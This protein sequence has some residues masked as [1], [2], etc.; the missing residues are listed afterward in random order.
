MSKN[1][2]I[3]SVAER[4]GISASEVSRAFKVGYPM[5]PEKRELIKKTAAEMGYVRNEAAS[6]LTMKPIRF[7]VICSNDFPEFDEQLMKGFKDA[8]RTYF[9]YKLMLSYHFVEDSE[10]TDRLDGMI[11]QFIDEGY[12]AVLIAMCCEGVEPVVKKYSEKIRIALVNSDMPQSGRL[13]AAVNNTVSVA[14]IAAQLLYSGEKESC[15]VFTGVRG[16]WNHVNILESFRQVWTERGCEIACVY[17]S[18]SEE[19]MRR[20]LEEAFSNH[21]EITCVYATSALSV[22]ICEYINANGL[23]GKVR[24]VASDIYERLGKYILD[25]T[26]CAALYQNPAW[27]AYTAVEEM[28]RY[29]AKGIKPADRM[30]SKPEIVIAA[31]LELYTK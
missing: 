17:N 1:I 15:A 24:V 3:V 22:P 29:V 9:A 21:P 26:V 11:S 31:N 27:Q 19:K 10:N 20:Q 25:G 7:A 16:H 2:S 18:A 6:R 30:V 12:D 8:E 28:Y 23:K 5:N 13:F 4:L 14:K